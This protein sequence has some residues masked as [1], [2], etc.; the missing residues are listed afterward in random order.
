[1]NGQWI[2]RIKDEKGI[3]ALFEK[4]TGFWP[5]N[6]KNATDEYRKR[7]LDIIYDRLKTLSDL[8]EMTT[9]FFSDPKINIDM[10]LNNKFLKK[11]SES[12][13]GS[14]LDISITKLGS[15]G[16]WDRTLFSHPPCRF[17]RTF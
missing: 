10:L 6:A 3:D 5:E 14:L 17:F 13:L 16:S 11:L 1:M 2:R 7:V 8:R 12:E 4:T 9:Y 15:L